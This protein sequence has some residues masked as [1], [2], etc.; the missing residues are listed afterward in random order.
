MSS[1]TASTSAATSCASNEEQTSEDQLL[2]Q[3][4]EVP[5]PV[6]EKARALGMAELTH[7]AVVHG[8]HG[9]SKAEVANR[10]LPSTRITFFIDDPSSKAKCVLQHIELV[11]EC[12]AH[13]NHERYIAR[14]NCGGRLDLLNL[15][16]ASCRQRFKQPTYVMQLYSNDQQHSKTMPTYMVAVQGPAC[17][18]EHVPVG[19]KVNMVKASSRECLRIRCSDARCRHLPGSTD[20]EQ[21]D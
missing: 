14:V 8:D 9:K 21:L 4:E 13:M 19:G 1:G 3:E 2:F 5:D 16:F 11:A 6:A 18:S 17:A 7:V 15:V 12:V 10:S 20:L